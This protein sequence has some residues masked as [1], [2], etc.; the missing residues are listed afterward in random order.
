MSCYLSSSGCGDITK[1]HV[2]S[3]ILDEVRIG[4]GAIGKFRVHEHLVLS[5]PDIVKFS[6]KAQTVSYL[7]SDE[8]LRPDKAYRQFNT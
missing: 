3:L 1:E 5:S 4:F 2:I 6:N 7:F 8:R